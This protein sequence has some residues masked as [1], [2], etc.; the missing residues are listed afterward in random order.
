MFRIGFLILVSAFLWVQAA[1]SAEPKVLYQNSFEKAELD[2]VPDEFLVIDGAFAV[3]AEN[4]NRFLE[5][6][7]APLDTF[8]VLFGPSTN[9]NVAVSA[10]ILGTAKG[11]RAPTFGVGLNGVGGYRLQVSPAKKLLELYK[12]DEVVKSAEYEWKSGE[13]TQLR[14]ELKKVSDN[15]FALTGKAWG[16]S[17]SEPKSAQITTEADAAPSNGRPSVVGSPYSGTPILFDDLTLST[18][19]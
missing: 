9:F 11:R 15:K 19:E 4:G 3:K 14:L 17:E 12:G 13:W 5:L 18:A 1:I 8:R 10:K 6:P 7:G 16:K 2:K